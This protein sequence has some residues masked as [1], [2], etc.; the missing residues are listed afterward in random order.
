MKRV[1]VIE[2]DDKGSPSL[3]RFLTNPREQKARECVI[4][5]AK[6]CSSSTLKIVELK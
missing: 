2:F 5:I 6:H 3:P 4:G 1:L